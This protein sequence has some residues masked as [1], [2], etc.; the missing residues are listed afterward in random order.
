E[1]W[2]R[3]GAA[4]AIGR[5][6]ALETSGS[7]API[8]R[9]YS[10]AFNTWAAKHCFDAM[11]ASLRSAALEMHQHVGEIETW[12][13]TL[14]DKQRQRL[15]GPLQN[16]RGWRAATAPR[17]TQNALAMAQAA[18]DR[19]RALANA[20]P[21]EEAAPLWMTVQEHAKSAALS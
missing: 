19:F 13:A 6:W 2:K 4:L 18:W 1:S 17:S 12:R 15:A 7:N 10:V 3:I 5:A 8:G 14:T 11:D 9:R 16:V 21:P 20:L